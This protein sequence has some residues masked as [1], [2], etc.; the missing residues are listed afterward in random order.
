MN[1][2]VASSLIPLGAALIVYS[3]VWVTGI[4]K[5]RLGDHFESYDESTTGEAAA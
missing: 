1:T 4:G 2:L 3:T 5:L